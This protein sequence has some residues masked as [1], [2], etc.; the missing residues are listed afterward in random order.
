MKINGS[1]E[2]TVTYK[3]MLGTDLSQSSPDSAKRRYAYLHNMYRDYAGGDTSLIES[4]PGFRKIAS[5]SGRVHAIYAHRDESGEEY[6][7]VHSGK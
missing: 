4:I 7:V 5:L 6:A 1:A 3:N 2:Y